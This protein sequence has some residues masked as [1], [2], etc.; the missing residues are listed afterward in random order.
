MVIEKATKTGWV[1]FVLIFL[2]AGY[3]HGSAEYSKQN[4]KVPDEAV[5]KKILDNGLILLYKESEPKGLAAIDISIKAG[6]ALEG[7]Y[8]GSGISH[9]VEHMVFKGTA[10]RKT[11]DVERQIKS[12]GGFING[13]VSQDLTNYTVI[14][15]SEYAV[16]AASLL[17]DILHNASFDPAE[18]EKEREVIL[19][20]VNLCKDDPERMI[21]KLM[22]ENAYLE[23]PY[24]YPII[25]YEASLAALKRDD[26]VK[27]YQ[28]M[29]VPNR[30]VIS[31]AGGLDPEALRAIEREFENFRAPDYS[32]KGVSMPESPQAGRRDV[33]DY[34]G[35]NLAYLAMGF[36]S[37]DILS[38]D[39]FAMDVL[40]M[41]LGMGDNSR[42][43][44]ALFKEKRLVHNIKAWNYTPADPGMF[45]V[46]ALL[47][48]ENI[49]AAADEILKEIE[50]I[51]SEG[52]N[53]IEL[54]TAKNMVMRDYILSRETI[55]SQASD[56][57]AHE[58]LTGNAQFFKTYLN[59][60]KK[61]TKEQI[62]R[63]A[64]HYL[65]QDNLTVVRLLPGPPKSE[66]HSALP[67]QEA[68]DAGIKKAL[69][70]NGLRV[71]VRE[72]RKVPIISICAA[73]SAGLSVENMDNNG[74]S[75]L[76][77]QMI[78]K[79]TSS[80]RE[81]QI[82][83]S[84]EN[85]GGE[86]DAFSGFNSSGVSITIL[87]DNFDKALEVLKDVL[88]DPVFPEEALSREKL[89]IAAIIK[90]EDDDIY[91][92]ASNAARREMFKGSAYSMR[93][94]G[95]EESLDKIGREELKRFHETYYNAG[96]MVISVSGD[97]DSGYATEKITRVFSGIKKGES[98]ATFQD[99][100]FNKGEVRKTIEMR[101]EESLL[102][103]SYRAVNNRDPDKYPL[104]VL[105][106]IMSGQS[107]RLFHEL[108]DRHALAYTLGCAQRQFNGGGYFS[109][110]VTTT[111]GKLEE[112]RKYLLKEIAYA[113]SKPPLPKEL[114]TAKRELTAAWKINTQ[115][116][117]FIS[118]TSAIDE[119]NGLG[120]DNIYKYVPEIEKV[121]AEDIVR[122]SDKYLNTSSYVEVVIKQK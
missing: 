49:D 84:I 42:L 24:K 41:I 48:P 3:A 105:T 70:S 83:G 114:E 39:L 16:N 26:L 53:D 111:S 19:K 93:V 22:N 8:L 20:E 86:I 109:F 25:G 12:Y 68:Q 88:A 52:V 43:N 18:I 61:V 120:Y 74:I 98:A 7:E 4:L 62:K 59:N 99:T 21:V 30:M 47:D 11:G 122:V 92:T 104:E 80:R 87:K 60:I 76:T 27:Y 73:V 57:G 89:L 71:F 44:K 2:L 13:S 15:P 112:S 119:L 103:L 97:I 54:E 118:F 6:A 58:I 82:R 14:V 37:V 67:P 72:N 66:S 17:K 69:L 91:A 35:T 121:T 23:H 1:S 46:S 32:P 100:S 65:T 107:G 94:I 28:S 78:L 63:A 102:L 64:E 110:Y 9:L 108:R 75:N 51:K 90:D 36:H 10:T 81:D 116:N 101:K 106:S 33:E 95:E 113:A 55:Q 5:S 79:G 40:S 117:D 38:K 45:G 50:K 77:A 115:T 31:I 34:A 96:N 85:M 56:M 29:Y